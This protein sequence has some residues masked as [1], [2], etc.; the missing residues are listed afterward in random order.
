MHITRDRAEKSPEKEVRKKGNEENG[1]RIIIIERK[2]GNG[3]LRRLMI[4][5]GCSSKFTHVICTV[6]L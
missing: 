3:S 6:Y 1:R 5:P 2:L 4:A